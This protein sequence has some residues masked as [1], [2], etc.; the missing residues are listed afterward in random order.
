MKY[1]MFVTWVWNIMNLYRN[2]DW[3]I[4][5][6]TL[7]LNYL[8]FFLPRVE[9]ER[10][11][12]TVCHVGHEDDEDHESWAH[13]Q[14]SQGSTEPMSWRWMEAVIFSKHL[15]QG[16][17]KTTRSASNKHIGNC[18]PR[19]KSLAVVLKNSPLTQR[20]G[21]QNLGRKRTSRLG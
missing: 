20:Y 19:F 4:E 16:M 12:D 15:S 18:R 3:L 14:A 11:W 13:R 5:A 8:A 10:Q 21:M 2:K 9:G 17:T 1:S 6:S 7:D